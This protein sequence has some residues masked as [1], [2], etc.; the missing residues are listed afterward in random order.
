MTLLAGLD[1]GTTSGIAIIRGDYLVHAEAKR[2]NL[3]DNRDGE[4]FLSASQWVSSVL[5]R[6][7]VTELAYEGP[8]PT[9]AK[10]S[11]MVQGKDGP[12]K[13]MRPLG[14]QRTFNRLLGLR[15]VYVAALEFE[16]RRR[17]AIGQ[18][19]TYREV[20][21]KVWR[22]V[23]YGPSSPPKSVSNTSLWWKQKALERCRLIRWG[24]T[25]T[26]AAESAMIAEWL[27]ITRKSEQLGFAVRDESPDLFE[28]KSTKRDTPF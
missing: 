15:G 5:S 17:A 20:N 9:N 26:D 22:S 1:T 12:E 4:V 6:F 16:A 23:V 11:V 10:K 19:F 28:P 8:L 18:K 24:V 2:L 25:Q 13:V 7:D 3:E 21:N 27:R 14:S